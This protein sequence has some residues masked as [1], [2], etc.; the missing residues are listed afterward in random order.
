M[1]FLNFHVLKMM[2]RLVNFSKSYLKHICE[3]DFWMA[4]Q[5]AKNKVLSKAPSI[6]CYFENVLV[7]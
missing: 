4:V 2:S 5:S 3:E 6:D 7:V 1:F